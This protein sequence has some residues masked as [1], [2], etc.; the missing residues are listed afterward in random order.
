MSKFKVGDRVVRVS[1]SWMDMEPGD[2]GKISSVRE[3]AGSGGQTLSFVGIA[4][5]Y[6]ARN[7]HLVDRPGDAISP[8]YYQFPGGHEVRHISAHL[9][10]YGGQAVQY[11]ARSTRLD[12]N[13]K[14]DRVENLRKAV[15][16]IEWEIERLGADSA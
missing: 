2:E 15:K 14:G 5:S 8:N 10:S 7:Y 16:L 11:V 12:G 1:K 13:N 6:D 9:T 4:G 3:V